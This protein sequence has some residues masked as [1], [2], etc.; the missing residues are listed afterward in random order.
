MLGITLLVIFFCPCEEEVTKL[1]FLFSMKAYLAAYNLVSASGWAYILALGV[2]ALS[3]NLTAAQAWAKVGTPLCVVQTLAAAEI[4]HSLLKIVKSPLMSTV[5]Q[6]FSRLGVLWMYTYRYPEA[7]SHW[8]LYLMVL[9]WA[10]VEVP[11]YLFYAINLYSENVPYPLFWLRYSLFAVLYP[12]GIS[13]ELLQITRCLVPMLKSSVPEWYLTLVILLLYL[14]GG[15]FMFTHMMAQRKKSFKARSEKG[16]PP[17][18]SKGVDF[19]LD[20][21]SNTRSTTVVN[22]G[23]IA[24]SLAA[25]DPAAGQAAAAEK[26]WRFG[27]A[28]HIVRNVELS[29][30]SEQQCLAAAKAGLEFLHRNFE[31]V[32]PDGKSISVDEAMKTI[33]GTFHTMEIV[34]TKPRDPNFEFYVPY[35][36]FGSKDVTNLKG[37]A[38]Q[39]QLDAWVKSGTIEA[40]A[41]D[42]VMNMVNKPE[43]CGAALKDKYF[44]LLGA[45]SAMGP[46]RVLLELGANI[47]A[48]DI[49]RDF[50]WKRLIE[51]ARNSP[52]RMIIPLKKPSSEIKDDADLFKS[53]GA[54][55]LNDTPKICNWIKELVPGKQLVLGGYAYLDSALFVR[56]AIAMDAIMAGVL[57][58]RKDAAL[59]FLCSPTDVFVTENACRD[60]QKKALAEMPLWQKLLKLVL[61][62]RMLTPNAIKQAKSADGKQTY[63][64]VDGLAVAQGPNYALAKRLQHW[65]CML[66]RANGHTVSTNIAPSTATASVVHNPQFAAAYIGMGYFPPMEIVYQDLSNAVMTALLLNDVCNPAS[67]ANPKNDI[68]NQICLFSKTSM[69]FGIWRMA[70]K[71]GSIGEVSALI[72]YAKMYSQYLGAA[73]IGVIAL[74]GIFVQKGAPHLWF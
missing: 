65:R 57:E 31:F 10:L 4:L 7:R 13:G 22:Q 5:M 18:P 59:A 27:Y 11:R 15:P 12:T 53:A 45:G 52:G 42:A 1:L 48:V 33:R 29:C 3:G 54:D 56:L 61:S 9:S 35:Q 16:L 64:I 21:K 6:V 24:A 67:A 55:L 44:V 69:H 70:F 71:C 73:S 37:K 25:V 36:K 47:I 34:G 43:F 46:L 49:D 38:L 41:R 62:K 23:A 72:G 66:A 58:V 32:L 28:K 26:N 8:S 14:P 20:V 63:S 17:P 50:V 2:S 68:G 40:D 39:A 19:P 30:G 51:M 74:A 60:A